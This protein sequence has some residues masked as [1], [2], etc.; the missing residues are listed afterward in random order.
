MKFRNKKYT[1][2]LEKIKQKQ[3]LNVKLCMMKIKPSGI[4]IAQPHIIGC[5]V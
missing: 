5:V 2:R 3:N 4:F 1:I